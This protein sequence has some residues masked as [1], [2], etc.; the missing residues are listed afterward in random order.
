VNGTEQT[1]NSNVNRTPF[2]LEEGA[3]YLRELFSA[4]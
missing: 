1:R 4:L 3:V 2:Q